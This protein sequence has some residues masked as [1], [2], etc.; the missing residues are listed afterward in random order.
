MDAQ[1]QNDVACLALLF[2]NCPFFDLKTATDIAPKRFGGAFIET[3]GISQLLETGRLYF[4]E[5]A[6]LSH[7][8]D[9]WNAWNDILNQIRW[10]FDMD[11]GDGS[12]YLSREKAENIA[13]LET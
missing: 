5:P 1:R 3:D 10:V 7:A 9:W 8:Q 11:H 6:L 4:Y 13:D 2:D 12:V